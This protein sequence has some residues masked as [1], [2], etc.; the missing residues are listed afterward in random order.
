MSLAFDLSVLTNHIFRQIFYFWFSSDFLRSNSPFSNCKSSNVVRHPNHPL[1]ICNLLTIS[2]AIWKM[3]K[4]QNNSQSQEK[5]DYPKK[6]TRQG[7]CR[8]PT[9]PFLLHQTLLLIDDRNRRPLCA[10]QAICTWCEILCS[11]PSEC[12]IGGDVSERRTHQNPCRT[13]QK[14]LS[15]T[16]EINQAILLIDDRNR[17]PLCAHQTLLLMMWNPLFKPW[18]HLRGRRFRTSHTLKILVTHTK[19]HYRT[20]QKS[21]KPSCSSTIGIVDPYVRT[22][23]SCSWCEILCSSRECTLGGDVSERRTH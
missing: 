20:H 8:F 3:S 4:N 13:H 6:A 10:H 1:K 18:V 17:R 7:M 22:K 23:P 9:H 11:S 15:H 5:R 21:T 2:M 16:P 19:N 14:S 12:T